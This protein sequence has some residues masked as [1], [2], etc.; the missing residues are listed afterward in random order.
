[1]KKRWALKIAAVLGAALL[2]C[3]CSGSGSV[4]SGSP[5]SD[6]VSSERIPDIVTSSQYSA[7]NIWGSGWNLGNTLDAKSDGSKEN[8]GLKTETS[9]GMP[10]TTQDMIN[11]VAAKGFK[12]IRIPVSWHNHI[13]EES[14][15]KIDPEW[16]ARVKTI[17]D[18]SLAAGM[19][20]IINIHHDNLGETYMVKPTGEKVYGMDS[21]YGFCV[22]ENDSSLKADSQT[23]IVDVWKQVAEYFKAYDDSLVFELLNEPRAVG[24]EY[25]WST[26]AGTEDKV[27]AANAIIKEY[28]QAALDEI[29]NTGGNNA[30]RYVMVPPY[31]ASPSMMN[32]WSLPTDSASGKLI[33]SVH[34]YTP[35][36]FCMGNDTTFTAAHK[37]NIENWLFKTL[38]QEFVSKGI[39]VI[40]GETS[41]SDKNNYDERVKWAKCFF[42]ASKEK[43]ISSILW[44][45]MVVY[46][47]GTDK[48]E[49]HGY[50][51]R[52]ACSWF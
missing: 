52:N 10:K 24:K 15:H 1:M 34:A 6:P 26:T 3:A 9:W 35:Y 36:E 40:I 30:S 47:T 20:V 51:N 45:N 41:A 27:L 50:F 25:E 19:K 42:G 38:D 22:P 2:V 37:S 43:G 33:V 32:G 31:A 21:T 28:E 11:A 5:A 48:A 49:R 16:L 7:Q 12:T 39:P 18:W 44:D 23:Y 13:T 29:R 46:P 14:G 17:V 4:P 8:L